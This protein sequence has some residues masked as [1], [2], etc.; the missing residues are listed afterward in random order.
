MVKI[1][2]LISA[3]SI[4]LAAIL[5][6]FRYRKVDRVFH[7]FIYLCWV[8]FATEIITRI[9]FYPRALTAY[10]AN[11]YSIAEFSLILWLMWRW[12]VIGRT[13]FWWI[14]LILLLL[15]CTEF[16]LFDRF[17]A[18]AS[19]FNII[20]ALVILLVSIK[21]LSWRLTAERGNLIRSPYLIICFSFII[22]FSVAT[23]VNAFWFYGYHG[24][25]NFSKAVTYLHF[26]ANSLCNINYA[27]AILC[28]P[29]KDPF[30]LPY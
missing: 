12:R 17:E 15:W 25:L 16:L 13:A 28:M 20:Y 9:Y 22:Y 5:G 27:I 4:A 1:A 19:Y 11:V 8:A 14:N 7:P 21:C 18:Y 26:F 3:F 2:A 10:S 24:S 6:I 30:I 29:R 23:I